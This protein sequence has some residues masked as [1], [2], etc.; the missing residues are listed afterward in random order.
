MASTAVV[1]KSMAFLS[2]SLNL[3]I[4]DATVEAWDKILMEAYDE[5]L[6][7]AIIEVLKRWET[8]F[9]PPPGVILAECRK[10]CH[11]RMS[12]PTSDRDEKALQIQAEN[13]RRMARIVKD[14]RS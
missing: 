8:T 7:T 6:P 10:Q 9:L 1:R 11:R 4:S 13:M 12:L 14:P 5:D 2:C 3:D